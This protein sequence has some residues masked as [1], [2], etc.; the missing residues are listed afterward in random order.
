VG[1][2]GGPVAEST[3][4]SPAEDMAETAILALRLND[5]L[6]IDRFERRFNVDF[7]SLYGK[8]IADLLTW[9]IL[10]Q[11][12]V[13]GA[14][15]LRLTEQGRLVGNEAFERFLPDGPAGG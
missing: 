14:R 13:A 12:D 11:V 4:I 1:V 9:K 8:R 7:G 5:G 6:D 3:A 10:E 2:A 15:R